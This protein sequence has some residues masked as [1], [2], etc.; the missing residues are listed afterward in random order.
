M[1]AHAAVLIMDVHLP[2]SRSLKDRRAVLRPVLDGARHRFAVAVAETGHQERWQ[3]AELSF[4][5]VG[6]SPARVSEALDAVERFIWSFPELEVLDA[7]RH[8]IEVDEAD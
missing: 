3:R 1:A 2:A 8:W 7:S 5:T 6:S 4:V